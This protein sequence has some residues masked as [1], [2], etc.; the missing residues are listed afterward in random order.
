MTPEYLERLRQQ[1]NDRVAIAERKTGVYQLLLP[2]RHPDGDPYELFIQSIAGDMLRLTD[3]G[4]TLMR[5][6]CSISRYS[7]RSPRCGST[8]EKSFGASFM[9][10][11]TISSGRASAPL[12]LRGQGWL[13]G[14]ARDDRLPRVRESIAIPERRDP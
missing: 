13:Q 2:M 12:Y 7:P 5:L 6:S 14:A 11:S 4:L 9:R 10:S 8:G 1:F 3:L